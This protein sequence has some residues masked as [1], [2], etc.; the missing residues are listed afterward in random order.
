MDSFGLLNAKGVKMSCLV[1]SKGPTSAEKKARRRAEEVVNKPHNRI[2]SGRAISDWVRRQ[3]AL[4]Q[5]GYRSKLSSPGKRDRHLLYFIDPDNVADRSNGYN[6]AR[7]HG[8][9]E[10]AEADGCVAAALVSLTLPGRMHSGF[11]GHPNPSW[12]GSSPEQ[13]REYMA[14]VWDQVRYQ[15]RKFKRVHGYKPYFYRAA[16]AHKDGTLHWHLVIFFRPGDELA[17]CQAFDKGYPSEDRG[18][19]RHRLKFDLCR[20]FEG[21]QSYIRKYVTKNTKGLSPGFKNQRVW[22]GL[23]GIRAFGTS[24]GLRCSLYNFLRR[25]PLPGVGSE[26]PSELAAGVRLARANRMADVS[27]WADGV[28]LVLVYKDRVSFRGDPYKELVGI[29]AADSGE[30]WFKP[31]YTV[32]NTFQVIRYKDGSR[33]FFNSLKYEIYENGRFGPALRLRP[34][35]GGFEELTPDSHYTIEQDRYEWAADNPDDPDDTG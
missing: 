2:V 10:Q 4:R 23:W 19:A 30:A 1:K 26:C 6:I 14:R 28:G 11:K 33:E 12:D 5:W 34:D 27:A 16:E 18:H 20:H 17:V 15:L 24:L 29:A 9:A 25:F 32:S 3:E 8:V 35:D 31:R 7:I 21:A 22:R 13:G